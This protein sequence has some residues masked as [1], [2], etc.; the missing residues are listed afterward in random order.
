MHEGQPCGCLH[1]RGVQP[2]LSHDKG[3]HGRGRTILQRSG[4]GGSHAPTRLSA[5]AL[6]P[7]AYLASAADRLKSMSCTC[8]RRCMRLFPGELRRKAARVRE[9]RIATGYQARQW[10]LC[11]MNIRNE[12]KKLPK[13]SIG[14]KK[15]SNEDCTCRFRE[16][17]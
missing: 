4:R 17:W 1:H 11:S 13:C 9:R 16:I 12:K 6:P 10:T 7:T 14:T 15:V 8:E 5:T 3:N 2:N